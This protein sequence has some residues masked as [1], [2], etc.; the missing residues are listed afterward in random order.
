LTP[1]FELSCEKSNLQIITTDFESYTTCILSPFFTLFDKQWGEANRVD[2]MYFKSVGYMQ[3]ILH[4][5]WFSL[6]ALKQNDQIFKLFN[7]TILWKTNDQEY[8]Q[9]LQP[10]IQTLLPKKKKKKTLVKTGKTI[11]QQS[12]GDD[13][14]VIEH[15]V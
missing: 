11:Y 9:S 2:K 1:D 15:L 3:R 5:I 7:Q 14:V 8:F 4:T 10:P 13:I 12:K 6:R